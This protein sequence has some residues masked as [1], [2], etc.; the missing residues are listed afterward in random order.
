MKIRRALGLFLALS[1][2]LSVLPIPARANS[3]SQA[4]SL[5]ADMN[6]AEKVGQ[7]FLIT[8]NGSN[9]SEGSLLWELISTYHI[10]GFV[11][12]A[13]HDNFS[14][15]DTLVSAYNLIAAMQ[16][17][18]WE[19]TQPSP[20]TNLGGDLPAYVP[21]FIGI[22][23][24][25]GSSNQILSGLSDQPNPMTLG[26][27]WSPSLA[28][29]AGQVLGSELSALGFNLFLGP[30][31]DV[32]ETINMDTA[33]YS[34][35]D[36]YGADPYWVGEIGRAYIAGLHAGSG[37]RLSV[38]A[39]HFP[40]LGSADRPPDLEV[41]TVRKS[42]EQLKQIELAPFF[43]VTS[44]ED[45]SAQ[46]DGVMVSHIRFQG[47]QG[48][49]RAT[50]R[51][52]SFDATALA[53]L[54]AV[55]PLASWRAAGGLTVSH[56]LGS[57]AVRSF[58]D[59]TGQ[60]FDANT[61]AG[62]AFIAGNDLLYLND[63]S[64]ASDATPYATILQ[65]LDYF[66]GKY[67]EDPAFAQRVDEA[68]LRILN[69]KLRLYGEFSL[70]K[71][72][73][74]RAGLDQIGSS[75]EFA[76]NIAR[77]AVT[78]IS[79]SQDY[80]NSLLPSPPDTYEYMVIF[81]DQRARKQCST[82]PP[83]YELS[84]NMFQNT[85]MKLYGQAG[86]NQLLQN[87][88][89]SYS[90][91]QLTE[92]LDR[93][94]ELSDPY[95]PD[96]L[97]RATW[98]IFNIQDLDAEL[99]ESSALQRILSERLDLIRDKKI[100]V[101]A[102]DAPYY[103]DATEISKLSA[104]YALYNTSQSSVDV[105][106]RVLMQEIQPSGALPISLP[107]VGYDLIFETSPDPNQVIPITLVTPR[108]MPTPEAGTAAAEATPM[109]LFAVG[110]TVR[111]QAGVI[112]DHNQHLVPDGTVVQFTIRLAGDQAIIG[113]PQAVTKDGFA[114]V[115]Y[116]IERDGI[117]EVTASSEPATT[118]GTLILNTQGG[119][120]QLIMPTA[121]PTL[122]PSPTPLPTTT[123]EASPTPEAN[124]AADGSYPKMD[125][126]LLTIMVM[127]LGFG[128]AF[129]SGQFWWGSRLWGV[130]AGVCA[131]IGGFAAYLMLMLGLPSL[132][133]LVREGGTWFVVEVALSG[134]L[135]GWL[136]AL[137]WWYAKK[138]AVRGK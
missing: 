75:S 90:F 137:V 63:F 68:V 85:L 66:S 20:D 32:A 25:G 69:A 95:L 134:M 2:L 116:R 105:A 79:P 48:N 135:F 109:P 62:T 47:F 36:I 110:E 45:P 49:I 81:S 59:P 89:S 21:L 70:E 34:G 26:A 103:L 38:I 77:E 64:N 37:K 118:S 138:T 94:T 126:W 99:P 8:F 42:L 87:R 76:F 7:L 35:E 101:F 6:P 1:L 65:T 100:I 3:P 88:L 13:D 115:E 55:E 30:T 56:S 50:T 10:G 98:V 102:Y 57:K 31:L 74:A 78:L 28:E 18:A 52:I 106:A 97:K 43:A 19:K 128:A 46:A 5:L 132:E 22:E 91:S 4:E 27:T 33:A 127:S 71:V 16:S 86:S 15:T 17:A 29:Q 131:L 93:K 122:A 112:R 54:L 40:G 53:Q 61:I 83:V 82:C 107:A 121:T 92:L 123:P 114:S 44:A 111:I 129:A 119:L 67:E 41:A 60:S 51:P 104:Y 72:I 117:F 14:G 113:Q 23:Q 73:P 130:R 108:E 96:N 58:F 24:N 120:A 125:D 39:R 124:A 136:G 133:A 11:L 80:L 9:I 12:R 84:A